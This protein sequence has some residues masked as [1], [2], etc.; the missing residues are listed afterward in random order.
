MVVLP[1]DDRESVNA[2][3]QRC[4]LFKYVRRMPRSVLLI[5]EVE[6]RQ[7]FFGRIYHHR[8]Y[9]ATLQLLAHKA[10]R[11]NTLAARTHRSI[12]DGNRKR[13]THTLR[14]TAVSTL[15]CKGYYPKCKLGYRTASLTGSIVAPT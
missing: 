13:F 10:R 8:L 2:P 14:V 7:T 1:R 4:Q 3:K 11:P 15:R 9:A 5:H 6:Q 12:D